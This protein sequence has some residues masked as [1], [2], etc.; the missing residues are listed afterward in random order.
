MGRG[1]FSILG[2][3]RCPCH[4]RSGVDLFGRKPARPIVLCLKPLASDPLGPRGGR[5]RPS[6]G[7]GAADTPAAQARRG[8]TR[9]KGQVVLAE[10]VSCLLY[11][12]FRTF[13]GSACATVHWGGGLGIQCHLWRI[14]KLQLP[15]SALCPTAVQDR[16]CPT[17]T[18]MARRGN[19]T[20]PPSG[21]P[22][23]GASLP[24]P[25]ARPSLPP[26]PPML[27]STV[28][29][30]TSDGDNSTSISPAAAHTTPAPAL[31]PNLESLRPTNNGT[32]RAESSEFF[33]IRLLTFILPYCLYALNRASF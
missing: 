2:P 29:V 24:S 30:A 12:N 11:L 1:G 19:I 21:S 5:G 25:G 33:T 10:L 22:G 20:Q 7:L 14:V 32:K 8:G 28:A 15:R 3:S 16:C 23:R 17:V 6:R 13:C 18:A 31:A 4:S 26:N 9:P 27:W